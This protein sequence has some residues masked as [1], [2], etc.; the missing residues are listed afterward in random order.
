M[1]TSII[2]V[3]VICSL[4]AVG[5]TVIGVY[6]GTRP[7]A[8]KKPNNV[9]KDDCA[10]CVDSS[11]CDK[12]NG[13]YWDKIT[14]KCA[15]NTDRGKTNPPTST[16]FPDPH[17][18][19]PNRPVKAKG[20]VYDKGADTCSKS[21]CI[22]GTTCWGSKKDCDKN[23]P[24]A[25]DYVIYN[26]STNDCTTTQKGACINGL[27]L[28]GTDIKGK[29]VMP[30]TDTPMCFE[31]TSPE[32]GR[33][34]SEVLVKSPDWEQDQNR[35]GKYKGA[36]W[37][38]S[39][40]P[41]CSVK[42][43]NS[44]KYCCQEYDPPDTGTPCAEAA[45]GNEG[46]RSKCPI[47]SNACFLSKTDCVN[48]K[49]TLASQ[50]PLPVPKVSP[51]TPTLNPTP[52]IQPKQP[53]KAKGWVYDKGA[54]T[55]S[56]STCIDGTTCWGSKNDCDKN[57]PTAN[58]YVIYNPS[59]ND[60][61][62]TQKSACPNGLNLG[63][64]DIKRK[65]VDPLTGVPMCYGNT[66]P[67]IGRCL[68]EVLSKSPDWNQNQ[69]K[70]GKYKGAIWVSSS[71]PACSVKKANSNKYCC[72]EYDPP[73]PGTSCAEAACGNEG[74][75]SKCPILG[76]ACF[77]TET[78][79]VN[80]KHTLASQTSCNYSDGTPCIVD[81]SVTSE[82]D[83]NDLPPLYTYGVNLKWADCS[84]V[85][86][87]SKQRKGKWIPGT[88]GGDGHCL[89]T[90]EDNNGCVRATQNNACL[91]LADCQSKADKHNGK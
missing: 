40:H 26:P 22:D 79:C 38:S 56:K 16:I 17:T 61:T 8:S 89:I 63:G 44:N 87:S 91:S 65:Y 68:S 53:V 51:T 69:N 25:N 12:S 66:S 45:C 35:S 84:P 76:N 19:Q 10:S 7:K 13:C 78:D 52:S 39:S 82:K 71:H 50:T 32:I 20:W 83:C 54:D 70:S 37:V 67:E 57:S 42:K 72:Q 14:G 3:V 88:D 58:D 90:Q 60:C 47:L 18:I 64:T 5:G 24:T 62:P 31:N 21:T 59:T 27:N 36:I 74:G 80:D 1:K 48:N 86:E 81:H 41:A 77:L 29:Y 49:H 43:A 11:S 9:C 30:L 34:L 28:G 55:C 75:R 4:I 15:H 46:G 23:S 2:V 6:F 33:C 85:E 73:G